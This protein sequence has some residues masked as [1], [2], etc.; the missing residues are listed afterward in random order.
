MVFANTTF[1]HIWS[2]PCISFVINW[3]INDEIV[4]WWIN[5]NIIQ[6]NVLTLQWLN[7]SALPGVALCIII[8]LWGSS[9]SPDSVW[10]NQQTSRGNSTGLSPTLLFLC[11]LLLLSSA[12]GHNR[13]DTRVLM[14]LISLMCLCL[15]SPKSL[16]LFNGVLQSYLI[17]PWS[18]LSTQT[19][20][21]FAGNTDS[22]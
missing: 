22:Q 1:F 4:N 8:K 5:I 19:L 18:S 17:S 9:W 12:F 13:F 20:S 15:L 2:N 3:L 16:L 11:T 21:G 10:I 6:A 7:I 14:N